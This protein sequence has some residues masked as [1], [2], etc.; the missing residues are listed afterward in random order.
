MNT[1]MRTVG[2]TCALCGIAIAAIVVGGS[3]LLFALFVIV[4]YFAI[5]LG[6]QLIILA[7][8]LYRLLRL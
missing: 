7:V 1:T 3:G 5:L 2:N 4:C 6:F 8:M